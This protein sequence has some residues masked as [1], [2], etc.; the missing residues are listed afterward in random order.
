MKKFLVAGIA[1]AAFCAAP[2]FAADMPV[3]A[4]VY[5]AAAPAPYNPWTGCYIGGNV[6]GAWADVDHTWTQANGA[7]VVGSPLVHQTLSGAAYGGQIGCD[8]RLNNNWVVGIRGMW[9]GSNLKKT[10]DFPL[11]NIGNF[12]GE[13]ETT[14]IRSFETLTG[15][16]G[17]LASPNFLFYGI[18]G[19][20]WMQERFALNQPSGG[21]GPAFATARETR[22]G[23]DVGVGLSWVFAPTWELWLEYDHMGFGNHTITLSPT[24][25]GAVNGFAEKQKIDK[26]LVGLNY[27]FGMG[28]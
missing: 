22:A 8:Y 25:I 24:P 26:V 10:T 17:F 20:A 7:P 14:K 16:V 4:P 1:V 23:Y 13:S 28:R 19:I 15:R 3:R 9:D 27:R 18:G 5:K 12:L 11:P 2:A 6:G 21:F